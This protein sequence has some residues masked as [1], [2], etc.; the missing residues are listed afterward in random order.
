MLG[1][2]EGDEGTKRNGNMP[3]MTDRNTHSGRVLVQ[4]HSWDSGK[5]QYPQHD[6][7]LPAHSW[8]R[9]GNTVRIG[10]HLF[11]HV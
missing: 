6:A 2:K 10:S 1:L 11:Q 7:L 5:H 3:L 4:H 9:T 8:R